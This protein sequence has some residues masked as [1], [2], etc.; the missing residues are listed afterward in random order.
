VLR[1]NPKANE[2]MLDFVFPAELR[3]EKFEVLKGYFLASY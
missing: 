2:D 3:T 1:I